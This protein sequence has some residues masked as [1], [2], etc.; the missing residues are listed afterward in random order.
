MTSRLSLIGALL[1]A[2]LA[3]RAGAQFDSQMFPTLESPTGEPLSYTALVLADLDGD[4][5]DD[6]ALGTNIF[7]FGIAFADANGGFAPVRVQVVID[8]CSRFAA[9]D[10]DQD[11][12]ID[13][14]WASHNQLSSGY[15]VLV[16]DGTGHFTVE[17][18]AHQLLVGEIALAD[19]NGD[20]DLDLVATRDVEDD[21]QVFLGG[22][23]TSF[24]PPVSHPAGNEPRALRLGDVD[25]D[26]DLDVVVGRQ[27]GA[28][29]LLNTGGGALGTPRVVDT[30]GHGIDV[31]LLHLDG[32]GD[33]DM[34]VAT[35]AFGGPTPGWVSVALGH[36]NG[37]FASPTTI[38]LESEPVQVCVADWDGDD[39]EDVVVATVSGALARFASDGTGALSDDG[40]GY[41]PGIPG[42]LVVADR[43]GDDAPDLVQAHADDLLEYRND[44]AGSLRMARVTLLDNFPNGSIKVAD[45]D[46]DGDADVAL[47]LDGSGPGAYAL[48][49][50]RGDGS[51]T[52]G[53]PEEWVLGTYPRHL[54]LAD[55]EQDGDLDAVLTEALV[56]RVV[57]APNDGAAGFPSWTSA[58]LPA[59]GGCQSIVSADLDADGLTDVAVLVSGELVVATGDGLGGFSGMNTTALSGDVPHRL[60]VVDLDLDGD[61]DLLAGGGQSFLST[62]IHVLLA[63]SPGVFQPSRLVQTGFQ[64]IQ[65]LGVGDV[66]GDGLLDLVTVSPDSDVWTVQAG[67]GLGGFGAAEAFP[68]ITDV[69]AVSQVGSLEVVDLDADGIDDLLLRS[70]P[71]FN[72]RVHVAMGELGVGLGALKR[73]KSSAGSRSVVA[74]DLNAD[75]WPEAIVPSL[76]LSRVA[77]L[78][79][80]GPSPWERL[81]GASAI[82]GA[83]GAPWLDGSGTLIT[84][85]PVRLTLSRALPAAPATLVMGLERL[86]APLFG[87]VLEPDPLL[88][89]PLVTDAHGF[90]IIE[91]TWPP[92]IP[93]GLEVIMQAWVPDPAAAL[94]YAA[95]PGVRVTTP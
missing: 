63:D 32:D 62:Q 34:V 9:G 56:S 14:A 66:D 86:G 5:R 20:G 41:T 16:N 23:G 13:L 68:L 28:A 64:D 59:T 69:S 82:G 78:R 10:V 76:A 43:N 3:A 17:T 80:N 52:L 84:G 79:N 91:D 92:G 24:A 19:M 12:D 75:G 94:G 54:A 35:E 22:S 31:A 93:S 55:L 90:V 53:A 15:G 89:L 77:V 47:T 85:E 36:G 72:A 95:S 25:G 45:L 4:G 33:L 57:I 2:L 39:H 18:L 8:V 87:G 48:G 7:G 27:L 67:D 74:G 71:G 44:G 11:G 46:G 70:G 1:V 50:L 58:S 83:K 61:L 49:V 65:D 40:E 37:L 81:T 21:V 42:L 26:G 29:V 88:L 6:A 38:N 60:R 51:A 73:I 30:G